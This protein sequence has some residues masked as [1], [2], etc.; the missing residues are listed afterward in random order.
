MEEEEKIKSFLSANLVVKRK[1]EKPC[2]TMITQPVVYVHGAANEQFFEGFYPDNEVIPEIA[3]RHPGRKTRLLFLPGGHEMEGQIQYFRKMQRY[4]LE[5]FN[6]T[7]VKAGIFAC[8]GQKKLEEVIENEKSSLETNEIFLLPSLE[9]V[10]EIKRY[11]KSLL[12]K[13]SS[14]GLKFNRKEELKKFEESMNTADIIYL[15]GGDPRVSGTRQKR[16]I[17]PG[18]QSFKEA[19]REF[20]LRG[21]LLMG[22]SA[23]AMVMGIENISYRVKNTLLEGEQKGLELFPANIQVHY[24]EYGMPEHLIAIRKDYP[25]IPVTALDTQTAIMGKLNFRLTFSESPFSREGW[26]N[27]IKTE[28]LSEDFTVLG[29]KTVTFIGEI[30]DILFDGMKCPEELSWKRLMG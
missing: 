16:I 2:Y 23:G 4:L 17:L 7:D 22:V 3:R 28:L 27:I 13:L 15:G 1:G 18:G 20:V 6:L 11:P 14:T 24:E 30:E 8:G 26:K 29:S 25:H 9:G 19:L 10:S 5:K 21:G 12:K